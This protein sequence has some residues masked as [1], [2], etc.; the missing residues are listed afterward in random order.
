MRLSTAV[1]AIPIPFL[2]R[3]HTRPLR[4]RNDLATVIPGDSVLES[5]TVG[6]TV[7]FLNIYQN[8]IGKCD[9]LAQFQTEDP[10][11]SCPS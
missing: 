7:T 8:V 5:T 4:R 3:K 6:G 1:A 10:S 9:M 11:C 2:A